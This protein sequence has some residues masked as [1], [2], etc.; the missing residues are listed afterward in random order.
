ME[1]SIRDN[2]LNI[3]LLYTFKKTLNVAVDCI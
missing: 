1:V 3:L 2:D